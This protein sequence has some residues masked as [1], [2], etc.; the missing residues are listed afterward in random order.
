[1]KIGIIGGSGLYDMEGLSDLGGQEVAT[2]FGDPS[3]RVVTGRTGGHEVFFLPRH[4]EGHRIAPAEINYRAN[5]WALKRLGVERVV[6]VSAV[7][8][9]KEA[10]RPRDIV[11]PDQYF[12]RTKNSAGQT[13]FGGGIVAHVA[14]AEPVCPHLRGVLAAAAASAAAARPESAGVRVHDGGTYVN[15]EGP[16]FSTKAESLFHRQ[17]GFAVVGMTSLAEAKLCREAELCYAALAMV[18]DY[19]CWHEEHE[20]V[21]VDMIYG[22]LLANVALARAVLAAALPGVGASRP[23]GCGDAL[24][25]AIVTRPEAVPAARRRALAPIVDRYLGA[26]G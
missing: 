16:A 14:F 11:L 6:S 9:L 7:G 8:S 3:G 5:I 20:A 23:C 22:H 26:A 15:M 12:D 1:M 10:M 13:F 25:D 24:R 4:G 21:T 18:T 17:C 2:P 19:D